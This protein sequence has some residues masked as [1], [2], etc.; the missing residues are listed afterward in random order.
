MSASHRLNGLRALVV[1]CLLAAPP[2][3]AA[4]F[5]SSCPAP[6]LKP[7]RYALF[8]RESATLDANSKIAPLIG[9]LSRGTAR[10]V[11]RLDATIFTLG[12]GTIGSVFVSPTVNGKSFDPVYASIVGA[13]VTGQSA[14]T[15]TGSFWFDVD[16]LEAQHPGQ[17][18][19]QPLNMSLAG[20]A[21][22][23]TGPNANYTAMFSAQVVKKK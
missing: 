5:G 11:L 7:P 6:C 16:E 14:C 13:C 3:L 22:S 15:V 8:M 4:S 19:G 17:F 10:T 12:N 21:L 18:V 9:K 1:G 2:A 23:G 20:G